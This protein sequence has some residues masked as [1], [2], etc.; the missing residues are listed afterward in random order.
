MELL[1]AEHHPLPKGP[2]STWT[3]RPPAH[4][5]VLEIKDQKFKFTG[6]PSTVE[7]PDTPN[8][9]KS[10]HLDIKVQTDVWIEL[11]LGGTTSWHWALADAVTMGQPTTDYFQLEYETSQGWNPDSNGEPC[12]LIRFG[13][14]KIKGKPDT[15]YAFNMNIELE[16]DDGVV[17]IT[18][19]PDIRNPGKV[20]FEE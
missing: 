12:K 7:E 14:R 17:P 20:P 6:R 4:R 8:G 16:D 10:C 18:I 1:S 9:R 2:D 5:Y 3:P 13:A 11:E 15:P 19:D